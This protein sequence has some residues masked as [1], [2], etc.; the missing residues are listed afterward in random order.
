MLTDLLTA[1]WSIVSGSLSLKASAQ[2]GMAISPPAPASETTVSLTAVGASLAP[3][4][5][6]VTSAA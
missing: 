1:R 2:A 4:I 3:L 5:A 6:T